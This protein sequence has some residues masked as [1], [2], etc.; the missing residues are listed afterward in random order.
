MT[1]LIHTDHK[2]VTFFTSSDIHIGIFGHWADQLQRLN[3]QIVYIPGT[4]NQV[5]DG[6][7]QTNFPSDNSPSTNTTLKIAEALE[8]IRKY[9][10]VLF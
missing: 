7:S 4:K 10:P 9:G 3:I 5:A 6:L 2:P 8:N 1:T